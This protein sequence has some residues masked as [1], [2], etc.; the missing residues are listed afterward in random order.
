MNKTTILETLKIKDINKYLNKDN[1][2]LLNIT[3]NKKYL[4]NNL[5]KNNIILIIIILFK[6]I[7]ESINKY[8][9]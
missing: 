8:F 7:K 4:N 6:L 9:I 5:L 1:E 3:T 2:K